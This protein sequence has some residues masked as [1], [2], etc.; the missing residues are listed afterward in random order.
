[1]IATS[2]AANA[3]FVKGLGANR[4]LDD[5]AVTFEDE[6]HDMDVVFDAVA[7]TLQRS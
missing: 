5:K 1:M 6:V 7:K 2:P 4:V 3:Q